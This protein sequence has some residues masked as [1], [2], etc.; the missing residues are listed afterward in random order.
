MYQY[1]HHSCVVPRVL[2]DDCAWVRIP[3]VYC[4][5][6][7]ARASAG[8]RDRQFGVINF[9]VAI[10]CAILMK[11]ARGRRKTRRQLRRER[12]TGRLRACIYTVHRDSNVRA[13]NATRTSSA[14]SREKSTRVC[15]CVCKA[16][17]AGHRRYN[18][19]C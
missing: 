17:V 16:D 9:F 3:P 12:H 4:T 13:A 2:S 7:F 8:V 11:Y 18:T 19:I 1:V 15:A 5:C 10:N 6:G 14:T